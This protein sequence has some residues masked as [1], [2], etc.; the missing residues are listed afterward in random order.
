M[1][2]RVHKARS[3]NAPVYPSVGRVLTK[4]GADISL[5][6]RARKISVDDFAAS[7]G[8]SRSTLHRLEKGDA[9]VSLNT[10]ASALNSLGRLDLLENIIDQTKDDV[11]LMLLRQKIPQRVVGKRRKKAQSTGGE[12]NEDEQEPHEN[13]ELAGW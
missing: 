6:R 2:A 12:N 11:A 8:V 4:L 10:L 1:N 7:M 9:G 13:T 3:K 5:A